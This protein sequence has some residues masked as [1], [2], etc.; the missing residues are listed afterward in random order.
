MCPHRSFPPPVLRRAGFI[1]SALNVHI[2][3]KMS[4]TAVDNDTLEAAMNSAACRSDAGNESIMKEKLERCD[5]YKAA[6]ISL[7]LI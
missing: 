6:T 2:L 4:I 1:N 3:L 5:V 7:I